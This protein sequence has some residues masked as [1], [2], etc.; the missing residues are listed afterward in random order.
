MNFA[1]LCV[2]PGL[3]ACPRCESRLTILEV[4]VAE[5]VDLVMADYRQFNNVYQSWADRHKM[6][7]ELEDAVFASLTNSKKAK[8]T[9]AQMM[10]D[11]KIAA[12]LAMEKW[13]DRRNPIA[14]NFARPAARKAVADHFARNPDDKCHMNNL[15]GADALANCSCKEKYYGTWPPAGLIEMIEERIVSVFDVDEEA[16]EELSVDKKE[17]LARAMANLFVHDYIE[18]QKS[19]DD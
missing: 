11:A 17:T 18:H 7:Q 16:Q 13:E 14:M 2:I 6:M 9:V 8:F 10:A 1:C 15:G 19:M 3:Q 4:V 5:A 12:R